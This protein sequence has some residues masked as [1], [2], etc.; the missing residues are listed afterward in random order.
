MFSRLKVWIIA[1]SLALLA[2]C[3]AVRLAYNQ[4]PELAYWWLDGYFDFNDQ[5]AP[6]AR[7]SL[8]EWFAW[9][10]STQLE[11]YAAA[12]ARLQRQVQADATPEQAC[13][14][15][16]DLRQRAALAYEQGVP[17]LAELVRTLKPEQVTHVEKRYHKADEDF[18]ADFL[19]ATPA[20]RLQASIKRTV[21]RVETLYGSLD[22]SQRAL[23][24]RTMAA[25]PFDAPR[26][27]AER[28]ARQREIVQT[29]RGLMAD[30]ADS[31]RT[32]AAL[33]VFAVHAAASPRPDYRSYNARLTSYNC[34]FAARLHNT[35]TPEQRRRAADKLKGWE[36]DL[37][38]LAPSRP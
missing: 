6:L 17:A 37:R 10:R 13:R 18:K 29:L 22:E 15:W 25:S 12:L 30:N 14:W 28:Q 1:A 3:S 20:E 34:E 19:Q 9:H 8:A 36:D 23:I 26:W 32:Q 16:D 21:S 24:A 35:T 31:A 11:D 5:Q 2:G 33:R 27:L 7:A 38:A 4:G